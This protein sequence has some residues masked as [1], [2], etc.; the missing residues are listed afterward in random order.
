MPSSSHRS[1]IPRR[2]A[3]RMARRR[4]A[5]L[6][7]DQQQAILRMALDES[8]ALGFHDATSTMPRSIGRLMRPVSPKPPLTDVLDLRQSHPRL[9]GD[10]RQGPARIID[11]SW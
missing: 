6:P 4:F 8:S 10:C 9:L 3:E 5:K 11:A 1:P 7:A 2:P